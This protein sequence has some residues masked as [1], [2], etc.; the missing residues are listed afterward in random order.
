MGDG[1][2]QVIIKSGDLQFPKW[3]CKY[4]IQYMTPSMVDL[5]FDG[6]CDCCH[7]CTGRCGTGAAAIRRKGRIHGFMDTS[8]GSCQ[9][10]VFKS[11]EATQHDDVFRA[12]QVKLGVAMG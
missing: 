8:Q 2:D 3:G 4:S 6:S 1:L 11:A 12:I 9:V 10:T 7:I 5:L